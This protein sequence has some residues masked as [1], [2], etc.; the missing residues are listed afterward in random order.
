MTIP[1]L[2]VGAALYL[3]NKFTAN[4]MSGLV[5]FA[6]YISAPMVLLGMGLQVPKPS[7]PL[8]WVGIDLYPLPRI[9]RPWGF[10]E[11]GTCLY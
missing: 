8:P 1:C 5:K 9:E 4:A 3:A 6:R 11:G 2:L 10:S 7:H